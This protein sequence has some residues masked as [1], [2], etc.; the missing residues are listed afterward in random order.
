MLA[1]PLLLA[2]AV[3]AEPAAATAPA[4]TG[5]APVLAAPAAPAAAE[6]E[7]HQVIVAQAD[8]PDAAPA[9]PAAPYL[10]TGFQPEERFVV[11]ASVRLGGSSRGVDGGGEFT[12][13]HR[14]FVGG[15]TVGAAHRLGT[16]GEE[17]GLRTLGLVAG[18]GHVRGLYR[19]EAL[20]GWGVASDTV[21]LGAGE[22]THVGH[23]RSVQAGLE[24]A[25]CGGA[26]WRA[27]LGV[28]LWYRGVF[29]LAASPS[30]HGEVGGGLKLAVETG[31]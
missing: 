19:G 23:F 8:L 11:G 24:R 21:D 9:V 5:A 10:L 22:V 20:L 15:V 29:G 7:G 18:Y 17:V 25:V 30:S 27:A 13:R 12:L 26:G 14:G 4:D 6:E 1:L 16:S 31:W 28:A 3:T 2:L